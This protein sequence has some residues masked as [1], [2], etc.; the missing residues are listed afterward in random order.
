[1]KKFYW[2]AIINKMGK[3]NFIWFIVITFFIIIWTVKLFN[4]LGLDLVIESAGL[5]YI[6]ST[7][8]EAK[9][10]IKEVNESFTI[11][12]K[13]DKKKAIKEIKDIEKSVKR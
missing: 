11:E 8:I 9:N 4:D 2:N 3:K 1:M 6:F 12:E 10:A 13:P 5:S 7:L